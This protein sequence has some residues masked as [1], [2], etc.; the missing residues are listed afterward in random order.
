MTTIRETTRESEISAP[1]RIGRR[2]FLRIAA[3]TTIG[4]LLA[5]CSPRQKSETTPSVVEKSP[6]PVTPTL[7][8]SEKPIP[9]PIPE[10]PITPTRIPSLEAEGQLFSELGPESRDM[11]YLLQLQ[12]EELLKDYSQINALVYKL[13]NGDTVTET[14]FYQEADANKITISIKQSAR[15]FQKTD[16]EIIKAKFPELYTTD[17]EGP[18]QEA[19]ISFDNQ[20]LVNCYFFRG[21]FLVSVQTSSA[22]AVK[23]EEQMKNIGRVIG[24]AGLLDEQYLTKMPASDKI[25]LPKNPDPSAK[26][27]NQVSTILKDDSSTDEPICLQLRMENDVLPGRLTVAFFLKETDQCVLKVVNPQTVEG[28]SFTT[29]YDIGCLKVRSDLL[30]YQVRVD[31]IPLV[32]FPFGEKK[33]PTSSPDLQNA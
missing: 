3:L 4:T 33:K 10:T 25:T 22:Q 17:M 1:R 8:I 9:S 18:G 26:V 15:D 20:R 21:N 19:K 24:L 2:P 16:L 29:R 13:E 11:D 30:Y 31:G 28:K 5:A 12:N 6:I 27:D 32:R 14:N 23:P 7:T